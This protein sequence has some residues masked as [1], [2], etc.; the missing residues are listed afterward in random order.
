MQTPPL[1]AV[2]YVAVCRLA[3][4]RL[5]GP[6]SAS[7]LADS[8][9]PAAEIADGAL[10]APP[11][12][13]DAPIIVPPPGQILRRAARTKIRKPGLQGDGGGHR[14][15]ASRRG[16]AKHA[17]DQRTSSDVSSSDH[18]DAE[19]APRRHTLSD[20][21]VHGAQRPESYSEEAAIYDAYV[22]DDDDEPPFVAPPVLVQEAQPPPLTPTPP[23]L[24]VDQAPPPVLHQPQPQR[25]MPPTHEQ[26]PPSRTPSPAEPA[27]APVMSRPPPPL[28]QP[29]P[30][31]PQLV[32]STP[33]G[34]KDKDKGSKGLFKWG[35]DK[36]AKKSGKDKER[37]AREQK[38]KEKESSFFGSLFGGGRKK[39]DAEYTA[40]PIAGGGSGARGGGGVVRR[41]E[42]FKGVPAATVARARTGDRRQPVCALPNP[43]RARDLPPKSYQARESAPPAI[44]AGAD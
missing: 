33:S 28:M 15:P 42:E 20:E 8:H 22:R 37:E 38:E 7:S 44:R 43:C 24:L 39:Q 17:Q 18:G 11:D 31:S 9:L 29:P 41:V 30:P 19:P 6:A 3:S 5:V 27:P 34:R 40:P 32:P 1:Y 14:F 35:S 13:A 16:T 36:G 2:L 23:L 25:L 12:E 21:G 4:L 10:A 26:Q